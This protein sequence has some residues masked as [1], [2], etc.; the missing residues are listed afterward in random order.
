MAVKRVCIFSGNS[1]PELAEEMDDDD[2]ETDDD[3]D[4][5]E[6]EIEL[7]AELTGTSSAT[8]EAEFETEGAQTEFEVEVEDAEANT[9]YDVLV[10]GIFVGSLVTDAAGAGSLELSSDPDDDEL[11]LPDNFPM[12][13]EGVLVE[14]AGLVSGAFQQDD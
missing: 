13:S 10:D 6:D 14:I 12:I 2:G 11:P 1:N 9:S 7:E 5:D 8:G 3:Q 4:V